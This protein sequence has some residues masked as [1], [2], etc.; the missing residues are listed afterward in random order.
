MNAEAQSRTASSTREQHFV[1]AE[2]CL[3][4]CAGWRPPFHLAGL[5]VCMQTHGS[6]CIRLR[7]DRFPSAYA[8][9]EKPPQSFRCM[10]K[11]ESEFANLLTA[12]GRGEGQPIVCNGPSSTPTRAN[13]IATN[14]RGM[15]KSTLPA[16]YPASQTTPEPPKSITKCMSAIMEEGHTVR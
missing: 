15:S 2:H 3:L 11:L 13:P 12:G 16:S 7:P 9:A 1:C 10:N 14:R 5:T 8:Q 4:P 6:W